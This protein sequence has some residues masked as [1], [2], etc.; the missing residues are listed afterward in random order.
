[1]SY[2][3]VKDSNKLID[4]YQ[5][6]L[7]KRNKNWLAGIFGPTGSGKS[8]SALSIA[9]KI[10]PS[11]NVDKVV[12][13]SEE[14]LAGLAED[15]WGQGD[16]L[17]FDEAGVGMSAKE[18]MTK[19]NRLIDQV[20]QTFR[21]QN[22][23]VLFTVPS[24]ANMDK[25]V[26]RLLHTYIETKTI[27]YENK[28]NVLKWQKMDYNRKMDKIYYKNPVIEGENGL[29]KRSKVKIGKPSEN[30][31]EEYEEKRSKFQKDKNKEF[32]KQLKEKLNDENSSK[33][34]YGHECSQCGYEWDGRKDN[35]KKCPDCQSKKWNQ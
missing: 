17:I 21:R 12:L 6:R 16:C 30:L 8:W 7:W 35:P 3:E 5:R 31:I 24:K 26:R 10:D 11:F 9:E 25:S 4:N 13:S 19:K 32:Y 1:M 14:F 33:E 15:K 18:H 2:K 34:R 27:D 23:A 20:L 22:I 28:Q 29:A